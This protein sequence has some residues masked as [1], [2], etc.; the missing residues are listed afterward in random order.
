MRNNRLGLWIL[1]V[2]VLVGAGFGVAQFWGGGE[3]EAPA[4]SDGAD[5]PT[6]TLQVFG[7][8]LIH[9]EGG[10][11]KWRLKVD[12]LR[13]FGE[14]VHLEGI[15]EGIL[16]REGDEGL[17]FSADR[18][19]YDTSTGDL[20]LSGNVQ[21]ERGGEPLL[22]TESLR[23]EASTERIT[24]GA[25]ELWY[26]GD[27]IVAGQLEGDLPEG[28]L[29]FRENVRLIARSGMT[30]RATGGIEY[31]LEEGLRGATGGFELLLPVNSN[32]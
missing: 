11:R 20:E 2:V 21:V 31:H 29:W 17:R 32:E 27:R 12:V 13:E 25:V 9:S 1:V 5:D 22:A 14:R 7:T 10:V 15:T 4:Q 18:G 28:T 3:T 23:W 24:T 26:E 6:P 16:Y 19:E 30:I 8:E